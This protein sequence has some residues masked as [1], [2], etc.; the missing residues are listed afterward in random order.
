MKS[1]GSGLVG[2][3]QWER[4]STDLNWNGYVWSEGWPSSDLV[5][6]FRIKKG[7]VEVNGRSRVSSHPPSICT[8]QGRQCGATVGFGANRESIFMERADRARET[9]K[10]VNK[11]KHAKSGCRLLDDETRKVSQ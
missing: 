3:V 2:R 5:S 1:N 10:G 7:E 4:I 11:L 6:V 8:R 9:Q